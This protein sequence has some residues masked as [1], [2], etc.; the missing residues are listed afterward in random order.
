MAINLQKISND[1]CKKY[2]VE[3]IPI[4]TTNRQAKGPGVYMTEKIKGGKIN[5]PLYIMIFEWDFVKK[6]KDEWIYTL[7][8]ELSH[9]IVNVKYGSLQHN[10]IHSKITNEIVNYLI[11]LLV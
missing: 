11:N 1:I 7:S 2:K 3:T 9:H 6:Y 5:I 8:H 4:K 10:R